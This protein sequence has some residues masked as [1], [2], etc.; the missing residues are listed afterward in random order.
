MVCVQSV[1]H[2]SRPERR[3]AAAHEPLR[4]DQPGGG[5]LPLHHLHADRNQVGSGDCA[6][7]GGS[8]IT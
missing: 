5:A 1:R 2:G 4:P 6:V 7:A 3:A 8:G